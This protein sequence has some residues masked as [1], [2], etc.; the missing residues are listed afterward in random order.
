MQMVMNSFLLPH[1]LLWAML[2]WNR[3]SEAK[4]KLL[5]WRF[6]LRRDLQDRVAEALANLDPWAYG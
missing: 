1:E 3:S 6:G 4:Q 5:G 2:Q